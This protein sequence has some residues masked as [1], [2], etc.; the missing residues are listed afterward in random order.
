MPNINRKSQIYPY[1][2]RRRQNFNSINDVEPYDK[3]YRKKLWSSTNADS[4][5]RRKRNRRP[6]SKTFI[7]VYFYH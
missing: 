7:K 6:N 2:K 4:D 5:K 3:E 1:P